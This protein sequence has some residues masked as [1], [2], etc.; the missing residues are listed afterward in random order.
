[1]KHKFKK[2]GLE[3][4]IDDGDRSTDDITELHGQFADEAE[5]ELIEF[6]LKI[7]EKHGW[8]CE[9]PPKFKD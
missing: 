1:M 6:A 2:D 7:L 5:D 8:I 3:F 9:P 4:I